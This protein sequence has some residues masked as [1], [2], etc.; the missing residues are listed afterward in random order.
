[1]ESFK[2]KQHVHR[3]GH[4]LDL[5]TTRADDDLVTSIEIRDLVQYYCKLRLPLE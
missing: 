3:K 5:L 1:M 2:L 4:I